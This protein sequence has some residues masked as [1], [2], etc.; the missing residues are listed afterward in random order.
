M[1]AGRRSSAVQKYLRTDSL[2]AVEITDL[3]SK[4]ANGED[5]LFAET[6]SVIDRHY[7][8]TPAAFHN[9]TGANRIT[10][11]A[12]SNEGSCRIFAFARLHNLSEA[13]T[14]QLFGEYYRKDVLLNPD[15]RDHM[16]IRTFMLSG[17]AG[18]EFESEPL[19]PLR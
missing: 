9:G 13:D 5:I 14:L 4:L 3:L 10:N 16:N 2:A 11:E 7:E 18:I 6:M 17:W 12:G 8:Y 1:A 19:T 15:R